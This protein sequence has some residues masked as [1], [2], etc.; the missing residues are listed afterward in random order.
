MT[1]Y[2]AKSISS[3]A[4]TTAVRPQQGQAKSPFR[5]TQG[6]KKRT[7]KTWQSLY[8]A[9][10]I[11]GADLSPTTNE[12]FKRSIQQFGDLRK[13]VTWE[14]AWCALYAQLIA[15]ASEDNVRLI[16]RTFTTSAQSE[17]WAHLMPR[18]L[19]NFLENEHAQECIKNGLE[20]IYLEENKF[21][22]ELAPFAH[23]LSSSRAFQGDRA[24]TL[25]L[26]AVITL[27][28]YSNNSE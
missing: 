4:A 27:I 9:H 23:A 21:P 12:A 13:K 3:P 11:D 7:Y 18:V 19:D 1:L 24:I 15:E 25:E 28:Q 10:D 16:R 26:I 5:N 6:L 2:S 14:N 8:Q 22:Q 20:R 17:G